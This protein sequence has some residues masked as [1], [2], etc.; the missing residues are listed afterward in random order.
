MKPRR[1]NGAVLVSPMTSDVSSGSALIVLLLLKLGRRIQRIPAWK[2]QITWLREA[3]HVSIAK[4]SMRTAQKTRPST[5]YA[6]NDLA[7]PGN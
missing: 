5:Q 4:L 7:S 3:A 6:V 2:T 1:E